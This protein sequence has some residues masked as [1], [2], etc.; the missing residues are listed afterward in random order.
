MLAKKEG[1][2]VR[3]I[4]ER[5]GA[6]IKASKMTDIVIGVFSPLLDGVI[7]KGFIKLKVKAK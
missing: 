5:C 4:C 6:E 1:D 2:M 7:I 3:K